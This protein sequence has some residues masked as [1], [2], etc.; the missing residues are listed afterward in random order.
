MNER[1]EQPD[2]GALSLRES[3]ADI[4]RQIEGILDAADEYAAET[5][6]RAEEEASRYLAEKRGAA[7]SLVAN[8]I[9]NLEQ[10]SRTISAESD[11]ILSSTGAPVDQDGAPSN[12]GAQRDGSRDEALLKA[13][14][15]AVADNSRAE[16]EKTLRSKFGIKNPQGIV[17]EVLGD[18]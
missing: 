12:D 3:V 17:D 7:E 4:A 15:M 1:S 11:Q 10:L 5:R 14:E 6:A 9:T 16:I 13:T 8:H 2:S 18:A